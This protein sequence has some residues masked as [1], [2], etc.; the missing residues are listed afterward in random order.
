MVYNVQCP[1]GPD[2]AI[3]TSS[4]VR[5]QQLAGGPGKA[6]AGLKLNLEEEPQHQAVLT[7]LKQAAN[8]PTLLFKRQGSGIVPFGA[9]GGAVEPSTL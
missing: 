7:R 1:A 3:E 9:V 8:W 4:S 2:L 5:V 6:V